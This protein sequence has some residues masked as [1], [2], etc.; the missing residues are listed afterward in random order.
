MAT[1]GVAICDRCGGEH[2]IDRGPEKPQQTGSEVLRFRIPI[3]LDKNELGA[4]DRDLC[5][6]CARDWV[7]AVGAFWA[8]AVAKQEEAVEVRPSEVPSV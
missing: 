3:V 1:K 5:Q 8:A 6:S 7:A 4:A 2:P